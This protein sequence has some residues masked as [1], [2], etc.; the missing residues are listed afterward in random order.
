MLSAARITQSRSYILNS[1]TNYDYLSLSLSLPTSFPID[2]LT[3][4]SERQSNVSNQREVNTDTICE[5]QAPFACS[6][7]LAG[8]TFPRTEHNLIPASGRQYGI[9][10]QHLSSIYIVRELGQPVW[11]ISMP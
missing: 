4:F 7:F 9:H 10:S 5:F 3:L 2:K 8:S 1:L 6:A 11:I